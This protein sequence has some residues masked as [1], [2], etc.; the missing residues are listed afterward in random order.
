[1]RAAAQPAE[2]PYED[3]D[4]AGAPNRPTR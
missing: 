3:R 4:P 2:G 1:M